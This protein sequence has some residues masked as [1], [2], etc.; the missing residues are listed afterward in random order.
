MIVGA[1]LVVGAYLAVQGSFGTDVD[2]A[3]PARDRNETASLRQGT[4]DSEA[5]SSQEREPIPERADHR[6]SMDA[7][8]VAS[9]D[10]TLVCVD[11]ATGAPLAGVT[12][13][14]LDGAR[15]PV[16]GESSADGRIELSRFR[17]ELVALYRKGML[18]QLAPALSDR[19]EVDETTVPMRRDEF[20]VPLEVFG[21]WPSGARDGRMQLV[22]RR[23]D[24]GPENLTIWAERF[25]G[26][27]LPA[28]LKQIFAQHCLLVGQLPELGIVLHAGRQFAPHVLPATGGTIR[29]ARP[30][31][32]EVRARDDHG[33]IARSLVDVQSGARNRLTLEFKAGETVHVTVTSTDGAPVTG[34]VVSLAGDAEYDFFE[35]SERTTDSDGRATFA[36]LNRDEIARLTV[37]AHGF[38]RYERD[39]NRAERVIRA[40]VTPLARMQVGVQVI[41]RGS[42]RPIAGAEIT[43]IAKSTSRTG[44]DGRAQIE[45]YSGESNRVT[46]AKPGY[47][48]YV[49]EVSTA[50]GQALPTV[51]FLIPSD[52]EAQR[53][54]GLISIIEGT[55]DTS[56]VVTLVQTLG[57]APLGASPGQG[58]RTIVRGG[59]A[60]ELIRTEVDEDGRF[61]LYT[62]RAGAAR[63]LLLRAGERTPEEKRLVVELGR[64]FRVEYRSQ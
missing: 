28:K 29:F 19:H 51:F 50:A 32:Y 21:A 63:V 10:S 11:A 44:R 30:G 49:E 46:I 45:F 47:L 57:L 60:P 36:G 38:Q 14:A 18:V 20:T 61:R 48:D 41:E 9:V 59:S 26:S 13:I 31:R 37:A 6:D 62:P 35:E 34:A 2:D 42:N 53:R 39:V 7:P 17:H 25:V 3:G 22:F 1:V 12:A 5:P 54:L 52:R 23:A 27:R 55:S 58:L 33:D 56:G 40:R 64:R 43:T 16:I 24:G 15:H 8:G 4:A